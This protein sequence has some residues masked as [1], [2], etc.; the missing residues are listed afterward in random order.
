LVGLHPRAVSEYFDTVGF[1]GVRG[2]RN[3]RVM[4]GRLALS[5]TVQS[6]SV[7]S[8][9]EAPLDSLEEPPAEGRRP[10]G[11]EASSS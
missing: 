9:L 1:N 3:L 5:G 10:S 6:L 8:G 2:I 11:G 7:L 4:L